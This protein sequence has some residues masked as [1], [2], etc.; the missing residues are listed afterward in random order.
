MS[1]ELMNERIEKAAGEYAA[2]TIEDYEV[3]NSEFVQELAVAFEQ[4]AAFAL[5]Y[6]W[7]KVE[8][9]LPRDR[10]HI[11]ICYQSYHEGRWLT[12]YM[13]DRYEKESG[14]NGGWIKPE[15]VIA[16]MPIPELPDTN[17]EKR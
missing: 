8:E 1:P 12:L 5:S 10:E 11:L 15:H 14:F 17:T 13:T 7:V 9:R 2:K 4:G 3:C 16:W 6:Q